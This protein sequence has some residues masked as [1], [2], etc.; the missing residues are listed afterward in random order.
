MSRSNYIVK[1]SYTGTGNLA[2]YTFDFKIELAEHLLVVCLDDEGVEIERVRGNVLG[3]F[4]TNLVFDAN[5]GGGTVTID[6]NLPVGYKLLLLLASDN[7]T[8]A[9]EFRNKTSFTLRR[10][11]D[12]LDWV[13]GQIQR[14][15]F[16]AKQSLKIHDSEDEETFGSQLPPGISEQGGAVLQVSQDATKFQFGPK[17]PD[18][19]SQKGKVPVINNDEDGFEWANLEPGS[20]LADRYRGFSARFNQ[21]WDTLGVRETLEE[22]LDFAY[23]APLVSLSASGAN[24]VREKGEVVPSTLLTANVTKRSDDISSIT[25]KHNGTLI[26]TYPGPFGST[27]QNQNWS[28]PFSDNTTFSVEVTD[29]GT[30][31]G[32]TT[33]TA[34]ASFTFVYP[35]YH[36]VG[37]VGMSAASVAALT[38]SVITSTASLNRTFNIA[39]GQVFYF[40]YPASYGALTAI[41]DENN[42]E[43]LPDWTLRTE[44]ITG[45]NGIPVSYRIYE[46]NNP[47]GSPVT[48][49][50]TFTR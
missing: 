21:D 18:L 50:Y 27:S 45:L 40:A 23:A 39:A 29:D 4:L 48:T 11:E 35:Y 2:S 36:G 25:F 33:V 44:N 43:T 8:Q 10:F 34:S 20:V 28:T 6:A 17:F 3:G 15:A 31:G 46:F 30:S 16:R 12:A 37:A 22:I 32:P 13:Q 14:L 38:K 19:T 41:K 9:F 49:N 47:A 24:V 5:E 26:Q 1:H 42:F 7:P